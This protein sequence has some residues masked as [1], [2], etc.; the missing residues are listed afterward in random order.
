MGASGGSAFPGGAV[1]HGR[2]FTCPSP[3]YA[4]RRCGE[5]AGE[6]SA[7]RLRAVFAAGGMRKYRNVL[8]ASRPRGPQAFWQLK[9]VFT[10]TIETAQGAFR[11]IFRTHPEAAAAGWGCQKEVRRAHQEGPQL[12]RMIRYAFCSAASARISCSGWPARTRTAVEANG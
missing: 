3:G 9:R 10:L 4:A 7:T 6:S 1:A 5:S 8:S 2:S 11:S 12:G